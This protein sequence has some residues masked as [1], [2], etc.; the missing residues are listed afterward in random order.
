MKTE[1]YKLYSI[2]NTSAHCHQN[3]SL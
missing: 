2:L 3:W 1:A